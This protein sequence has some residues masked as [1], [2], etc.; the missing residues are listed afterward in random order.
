M[1]PCAR[2]LVEVRVVDEDARGRHA[3]PPH[4]TA[5][6]MKLRETEAR[7]AANDHE[8]GLG[9]VDADLENRCADEH[10]RFAATKAREHVGLV[11]HF[12]VG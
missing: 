7:C 6:L 1:K 8:R 10:L 3:P 11:R 12:S 2:A 4:A 9:D 5:Q